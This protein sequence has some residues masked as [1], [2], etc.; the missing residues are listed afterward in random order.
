LDFTYAGLNFFDASQDTSY[1]N[2]FHDT[3]CDYRKYVEML[4]MV[5]KLS[6]MYHAFVLHEKF[7]LS[8]RAKERTSAIRAGMAS[9]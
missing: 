1:Q 9:F 2:S 3:K 8:V 4:N 5:M 7:A 6:E